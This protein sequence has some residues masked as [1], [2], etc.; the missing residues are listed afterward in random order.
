MDRN[1]T[2]LG[3]TSGTG[4]LSAG[5]NSIG[6]TFDG[7][8][9]GK[10]G[11][12]GPYYLT[13]V[14]IFSQSSSAVLGRVYTTAAYATSAFEGFRATDTLPPS[15]TYVLTPLPNSAGW[16]KVDV[17]VALTATD[18]PGGSGV[19]DITYSATGAQTMPPAT[20]SGS[21]ATFQVTAEGQTT[22]TYFATD[23]SGNRES[24]STVTIRL[25]KVRPTVTYTGNVGSY[26]IVDIVAITC[27]ATDALSGVASTT[28][29]DIAGPA[30][31]F[32]AG[33]N[34]FSAEAVDKADNQATATTS[35]TVQATYEDLCILTRQFV[36]NAGV[37]L[38][39]AMCA[40]LTT[41]ETAAS[42]GD[43]SAQ[44]Q[45]IT[46]YKNNVSAG[47]RGGFLT[48][49]HGSILTKWAD[50]LFSTA[51][52]PSSLSAASGTVTPVTPSEGKSAVP[53]TTP[54]ST[55]TSTPLPTPDPIASTSTSTNTAAMETPTATATRA[56][57]ATPTTT[58]TAIGTRSAEAN[59]KPNT[60]TVS[61]SP[62]ATTSRAEPR[63][64]SAVA[65]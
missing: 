25:D 7:E 40:Q 35:F 50:A 22:I 51:A 21:S 18:N 24:P 44:S 62:T 31:S 2:E 32:A 45:A 34:T 56:V 26:G 55:P 49:S 43:F 52:V 15:T 12:D 20:V 48:A 11:S 38:S 8:T 65:P 30:Y 10:S 37:A 33:V 5:T 27:T 42:R 23:T 53:V 59:G 4:P 36:T 46:A 19:K 16:N 17:A 1:G 63:H 47:V 57:M 39:R 14:L 29:Q 64:R 13:D 28:C 6:F 3:F 61:T 54:T 58:A 41:A 60:V 9:I